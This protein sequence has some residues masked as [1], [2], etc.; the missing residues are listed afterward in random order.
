MLTG[1]TRALAGHVFS[2]I[3][4]IDFASAKFSIGF[5]QHYVKLVEIS[6]SQLREMG[7]FV[8]IGT[9]RILDGTPSAGAMMFDRMHLASL[10]HPLQ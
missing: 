7:G 10:W 4:T 5:T 2:R 8:I 3:L 6:R 9:L 1:K